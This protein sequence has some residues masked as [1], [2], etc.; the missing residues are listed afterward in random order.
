[1]S[2]HKGQ[3]RKLAINQVTLLGSH[4]SASCDITEGSPPAKGYLTHTGHHIKRRAS[5]HDVGSAV[6]QSATIKAQLEYGVRHLDLRIA[7]Q[8]GQYWGI[9]EWIS[10]PA[11]G[12][13]GVFTQI[14]D[15]LLAHPDEVVLL[16]AEHLYSERGPMTPSQAAAFYKKVE[17][18][19]GSLMAKTGGFSEVTY[20]DLW[21]GTGRVI[22]ISCPDC[23]DAS[24]A[25]LAQPRQKHK[26]GVPRT[27]PADTAEP[28]DVLD[29]PYLWCGYEVDAKWLDEKNPDVLIAGLDEIIAK[30]RKGASADKLRRLQAMATAGHKITVARTVNPMVMEKLKADWRDAPISVVQVD[31]AVNSGLMPVLIDKLNRQSPP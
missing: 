10:T 13:G 14:K 18:E 2:Q 24:L 29:D 9:H 25:S 21:A 15:F 8:D 26:H 28:S 11:F 20:G 19:L 17:K 31:D 22:F 30:W 12:P 6:C 4:D 7:H 16:T 27:P 3:M 5:A 1:M 23:E